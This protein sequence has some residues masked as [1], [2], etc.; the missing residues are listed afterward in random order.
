MNKKREYQKNWIKKKKEHG[1]VKVSWILPPEISFYLTQR[2][3]FLM[4]NYKLHKD[5]ED[6]SFNNVIEL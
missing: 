4:N 1:W 5:M 3:R 2:K 6:I